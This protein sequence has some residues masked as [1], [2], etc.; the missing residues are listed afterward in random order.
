MCEPF[1]MY[2]AIERDLAPFRRQ[3]ANQKLKWKQFQ[4][5]ATNYTA[6]AYLLVEIKDRKITIIDKQLEEWFHQ[7][8][9]SDGR[10]WRGFMEELKLQ[11]N[12]EWLLDPILYHEPPITTRF[13]INLHHE[14]KLPPNAPVPI[15]SF[16]HLAHHTDK[17]ERHPGNLSLQIANKNRNGIIDPRDDTTRDL[18]MP[19]LY[20]AGGRLGAAGMTSSPAIGGFWFWPFYRRG[21]AWNKRRNTIVWRGSTL[22]NYEK[23]ATGEKF[24]TGPRFTM[25]KLWAGQQ[26][27]PLDE[28]TPVNID[29]A[30]TRFIIQGD[31]YMDANQKEA[32]RIAAKKEYRFARPLSYGR[33]QRYKYLLDVDGNGKRLYV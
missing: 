19:H 9:S 11:W 6:G 3:N 23:N 12:L 16:H 31:E 32:I 18:L 33:L 26:V 22:G 1:K 17:D 21:K 14:P 15:F 2:N 8:P 29:F 30:F 24:F 13:V 7:N 4:H 27:H 20:V 5:V 10:G 25:M 28:K